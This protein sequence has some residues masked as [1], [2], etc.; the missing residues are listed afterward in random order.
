MAD[1]QRR[2][3]RDVPQS[4]SPSY[5]KVPP[6]NLDAEK[7]LLGAMMLSADAAST[8]L[9]MVKHDD[10]YRGAHTRIYE[11]VAHLFGRGEP[12]D[13]VTVAARLEA[14]GELEQVG[15]KGYLL[16]IVNTVPLAG[17]VA[18][19]GTIVKRTSMLRRLIEAAT[20]IAALG[21]EA[22]DDVDEVVEEAERLIFDVTNERV[23]AN[24][25]PID[26]LLAD[27][28][29]KL[30]ELYER[31]EHL[32]GITTGFTDLDRVLAGMHRGDMIVLAARPSVGKTAFALN[33]AVNAAKAGASVAVFSL[34][35]SSE[36]LVMRMLST[37]SRVDGQLLRT[38]RVGDEHWPLLMNAM[39]RL[40]QCDLHVDDTAGLS[41]LELRAKARRLLRGK[42]N[43][44]VIVDYLQ[45]MQPGGR[46]SEN[47]Q[48]EIAEI[49]R[50]LKILAKELEVPVLALSQLSRAVEQRASKRPVL[51]DLRECV[52]GDTLVVMA[53]GRRL[54]I[55]DLVGTTPSVLAVS[56]DGKIVE[57][58]GDAVWCVG[59]RP[60]CEVVTA[61]GRVLSA[62]GRHRLLTGRGWQRL[63]DLEP[64]E[65]VALA[66][67]LP[68]PSFTEEWPVDRLVLLGH[69]VG[70]GSYLIGQPMR[71]TTASEANSEAVATAA[72]RGF[73]CETS[74]HPGRGNWHQLVIRGNGDRWHSAGVGAWL[75]QLGIHGQRSH[76]KRLP[77]SLFSLRS[78]QIALFLR[79][80]WATDGCI[81][82]SNRGA[83]RGRVF[84][85]TCSRGLAGDVAHLL[86]RLGIVARIRTVVSKGSVWFT[87]DVSGSPGQR[88]FLETVG[89]F[90]PREAQAERLREVLAAT[91]TNTNVDTLPIEVFGRVRERMRERGITTRAMAAARGTSYGGTS[92][93]R[94][95][96]SRETVLSYAEVLDDG[97]LRRQATNDLFWDAIVSIT[98]AGTAPVYDL[99]VPGPASW[100]AD[101]LVSHNS[102]AIE[103][104]ADVVMFIHR[105]TTGG[106]TMDGGDGDP[107][108][109][110]A[111]IIVAKHRN[112]PTDTV[113]LVYHEPYMRFIE[114]AKRPG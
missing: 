98:P 40:D 47:R 96:P 58:T 60:V 82:V 87:V 35:M 107:P 86:L 101:G 26:E 80:L 31:Q 46:R 17:N 57:A 5:D 33:V 24:F 3:G 62:T 69:L 32:T 94:F 90:G 85:A 92:H 14:S 43:G 114:P 84:F 109:G 37:E 29:K 59:T 104:D 23:E 13:V 72:R 48:V 78:G 113:R 42:A 77:E 4:A 110:T 61:S 30:E 103:Q 41:V 97:G 74:R 2:D 66:R 83:A 99:T 106:D 39:G 100:L 10:F 50:G 38:G 112:G 15:G 7:S 65:R 25:R 49:S 54:P 81:W 70:D 89:G 75:K 45:L 20:H 105:D 9:G 102:G 11:A 51:S 79:H 53:D 12:I 27:G 71:Y 52:T 8:G 16:D 95:A 18:Q 76:E 1:R 68:E 67:V 55:A 22:P 93:F 91:D 19:Y 36:Q 34:E 6:H 21:Y 56:E 44:L 111:D 64:G 108:K 73:G 88:R 63:E 28:W